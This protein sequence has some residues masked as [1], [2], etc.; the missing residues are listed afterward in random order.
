MGKIE[1]K[2]LG[3]Q[4]VLIFQKLIRL[5]QEVFE[6]EQLIACE[7]SYLERLLEK[8]GFIAYSAIFE[9]EV[10]GG[11]TAYELPMY[12][13]ANSEIFI[14]DIAIRP[15]FQRKGVGK[16]LLL[17]LEEYCRQNGINLMFVAASEEDE[18]ALD[19]YHSTGGKAEKVVHFN[20]SI[21]Q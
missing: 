14:Y 20:Y 6:T 3:K 19:F 10:V 13:T 17:S 11:L 9:N 1:I 5:F 15:A 12:Y 7:E 16:K 8:P 18:H 4:N 21:D 2:R